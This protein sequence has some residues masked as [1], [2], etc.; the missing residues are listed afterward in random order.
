MSSYHILK[1]PSSNYTPPPKQLNIVLRPNNWQLASHNTYRKILLRYHPTVYLYL[2]LEGSVESAPPLE[3][4]GRPLCWGLIGSLGPYLLHT[5]QKPTLL[6]STVGDSITKPGPCLSLGEGSGWHQ[7]RNHWVNEVDTMV[8][9]RSPPPFRVTSQTAVTLTAADP[10][11]GV[12]LRKD[13]N[14]RSN[15]YFLLILNSV[16]FLLPRGHTGKLSMW[17]SSVRLWDPQEV[18]SR[19]RKAS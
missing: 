8:L 11:W 13:S 16:G 14:P 9:P 17:L 6:S 1:Q 3:H 5:R 15:T 2:C 12:I 18:R 10:G 4:R 7:W 19:Y